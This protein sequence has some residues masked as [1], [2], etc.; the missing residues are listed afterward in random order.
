M[1]SSEVF[2]GAMDEMAPLVVQEQNFVVE[3]FHASSLETTDFL[4]AIQQAPPE[5]RV[6]MNLLSPKP[7]DPDR[8]MAKRVTGVMDEVFGFF[9]QEMQTLLEWS[10]ASDPIQGVG[11]M[12]SLSRHAF[13]LQ[14]S[15]QEFL[16][17]LLDQMISKLQSLWAKF[18]DEQIRAIEDTKVKIKKRK[19]VIAFMKIFPHFSAAVENTFS[20]IAGPDYDG[21]ADSMFE[22]RR[23]VDEAYGRIN[24]A[25]FDSLKVIAKESPTAVTQA[26]AAKVGAAADD[27]EDKEMLNY[28]ILIIENMNHYVEEVDDGGKEGVLAEWKGRALMERMEALEGY[29]GGLSEGLWGSCW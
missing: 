6:G 1:M 29:V 28:H 5:A 27:P 25:M 9:G 20:S 18:V 4:D 12:A 26:Q 23:L 8:E 14:E 24:R 16:L 19:G 7:M 22:T 10:V 11:V 13:F 17:Q 15:S 3:V 21:P 2:A